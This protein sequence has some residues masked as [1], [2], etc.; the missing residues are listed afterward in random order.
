MATAHLRRLSLDPE[1]AQSVTDY[2]ESYA[3]TTGR[4][5]ERIREDAEARRDDTE[6]RGDGDDSDEEE[7]YDEET[8]GDDDASGDDTEAGQQDADGPERTDM[9]WALTVEMASTLRQAASWAMYFDISRARSLLYRAGYLYQ[10]ADLAFGSFLLTIAGSPPINQFQR[11]VAMLAL[12]HGQ[13]DE[14]GRPESSN[15][16]YSLEIPG[17]L[18]HPQQQTYL[19]LACAGMADRL[20]DSRRQAFAPEEEA[21]PR[22]PLR[23][24]AA[25]SPNL[26]GVLPFGS[27]GTPVRVAWDIGAHLLRPRNAD[28]LDIVARHLAGL[29]RRYDEMM[30]LA[31]VN[32]HLWEHAAAPVDVGDIEVIGITALSISH[33]GRSTFT[34]A[35]GR[36]LDRNDISFIPFDLGSELAEGLPEPPLLS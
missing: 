15:S 30:N 4:E 8:L 3:N 27:L 31:M 26:Q 7:D 11:D 28:S 1:Q 25:E 22:R 12:L 19:L 9:Q 18:Y 29:Y 32:N 23:E 17:P 20:D 6:T 33:F 2:L 13:A 10:S 14:P 5:L 24:I 34:E 36:G 35:V 16:R 21:D